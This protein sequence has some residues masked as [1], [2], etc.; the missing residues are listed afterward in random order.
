MSL[1]SAVVIH[2]HDMTS[3]LYS[4]RAMTLLTIA[5]NL[6]LPSHL[7]CGCQPSTCPKKQRTKERNL[8]NYCKHVL[9]SIVRVDFEYSVP[10]KHK[11]AD[12]VSFA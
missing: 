7:P 11:R 2:Y 3:T 8:R 5:C 1:F 12:N 4:S 10:L 9:Y 6:T